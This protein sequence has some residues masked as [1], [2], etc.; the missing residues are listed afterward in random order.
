MHDED[1]ISLSQTVNNVAPSGAYFSALAEEE[2]LASHCNGAPPVRT[3]RSKTF[4]VG[5]SGASRLLC[6]R[7]RLPGC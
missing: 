2:A 5:R 4:Q 1:L 6:V 7:R 3:R